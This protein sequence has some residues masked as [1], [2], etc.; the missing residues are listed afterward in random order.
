MAELAGAVKAAD[1]AVVQRVAHTIKGAVD[2]CGASAAYEIAMRLERMGR[3]GE[4]AGAEDV[5]VELAAELSRVEPSLTAYVNG[6]ASEGPRAPG[7][8]ASHP[9][10][11]AAE[12]EG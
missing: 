5:R 11:A 1:A 6:A 8:D 9:A 12:R 3:E 10:P 2:N 4:L 7:A